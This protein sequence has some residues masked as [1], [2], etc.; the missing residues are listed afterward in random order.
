MR[1]RNKVKLWIKSSVGGERVAMLSGGEAELAG[2]LREAA[3][4]VRKINNLTNNKKYTN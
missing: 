3:S 1:K 4:Q 2:R